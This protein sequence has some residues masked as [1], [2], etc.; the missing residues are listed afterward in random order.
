MPIVVNR[1]TGAVLVPDI[2]PEQQELLFGTIIQAY[3]EQHPEVL[4]D[5][6]E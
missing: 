2:T 4:D 5:I 1:A 6:Q 3:I